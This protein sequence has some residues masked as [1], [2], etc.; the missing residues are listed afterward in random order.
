[1]NIGHSSRL[2]Y[3][4]CYYPDRLHESV[5][6]LGYRINPVQIQNCDECLSTLGPRSSYMGQ[7]VSTYVGHPLATSQQLVDIESVLS[8]RNVKTSKCKTGHLNEL[9]VTKLKLKNM[10][11]CDDYL[12][13]MSSRLSYPPSNY[14][15]TAINRFYNLHQNPQEPIFYDFAVNTKLEAKDNFIPK[16]PKVKAVTGLPKEILGM[17]KACMPSSDCAAYCPQ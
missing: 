1:M 14:R 8:N 16:L 9:D 17:N 3:D 4:K 5:G 10:K 6:P 13:P 15:D 7:G 12:N 11:I 2:G